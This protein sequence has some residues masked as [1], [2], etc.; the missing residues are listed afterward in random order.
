MPVARARLG[1]LTAML[2]AVAAIVASTA[3][4]QSAGT[5]SFPA[6]CRNEAMKPRAITVTCADANF[7]ITGI[8]WTAWT[9]RR[10]RGS[11]T[12]KVNACNP[13]CVQGRFRSYPGVTVR[14]SH[15]VTCTAT[16]VKQ[17]TRLNY[18]FTGGRPSDLP[19][20]G[21]QLYRCVPQGG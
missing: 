11:G 8:T 4:A 7:R 2:A 9:N 18:V 13:N 14:L 5:V 1:M 16:G 15:P 10:A 19:K 21:T 12:A 17:F 20:A 3:L 6:N